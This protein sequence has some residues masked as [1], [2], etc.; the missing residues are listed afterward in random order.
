MRRFALRA[1]HARVQPDRPRHELERLLVELGARQP[2]HQRDAAAVLG[3]AH[4]GVDDRH[5]CAEIEVLLAVVEEIFLRVARFA[6]AGDQ[7]APSSVVV[8]MAWVTAIPNDPAQR[9]EVD[10]S[11]GRLLVFSQGTVRE[12]T[13]SKAGPSETTRWKDENGAP[14]VLPPGPVWVEVVPQTA[15]ID[16]REASGSG[17]AQEPSV[18][19]P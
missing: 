8:Q 9:L 2:F 14:M 4:R 10:L 11:G 1:R 17:L 15:E 6:E 13:W 12:G 16:I 19:A 3:L 5:R 7:I 18:E